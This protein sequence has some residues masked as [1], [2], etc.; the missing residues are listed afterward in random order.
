[1][2]DFLWIYVQHYWK[3]WLCRVCQSLLS[4]KYQGTRQSHFLPSAELGKI[5]H[6]AKEAKPT[7]A[8]HRALGKSPR[9][10]RWSWG[11]GG[12]LPSGFAECQPLDTRQSSFN[13][14]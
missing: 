1:V 4:A 11:D 14:L 2:L 7:F 8:E 12:H 9:R 13:F 6:S 3:S 10:Q 5:R